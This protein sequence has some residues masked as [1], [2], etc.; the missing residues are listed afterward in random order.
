MAQEPHDK[1]AI[2]KPLAATERPANRADRYAAGK[3]LRDR[4][5]LERHGL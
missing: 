3:A 5:P 1:S 4:V 2:E